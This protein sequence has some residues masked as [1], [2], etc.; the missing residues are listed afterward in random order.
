MGREDAVTRVR[1]IEQKGR[2]VRK[3][4]VAGQNNGSQICFDD[5]DR[6]FF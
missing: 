6:K 5:E 1:E 3:K 2:R 4:V